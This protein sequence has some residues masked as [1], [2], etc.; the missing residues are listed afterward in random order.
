MI[1]PRPSSSGANLIDIR[2][3]VAV[4]QKFFEDLDGSRESRYA[5]MQFYTKLSFLM[6]LALIALSA[7]V[8]APE[9]RAEVLKS[10]Y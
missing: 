1:D 8:E 5:R 4:L 10:D 9:A 2:V 3:L 6:S 7:H